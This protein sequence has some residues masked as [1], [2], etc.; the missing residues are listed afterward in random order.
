VSLTSSTEAAHQPV[1]A[2]GQSHG[3]ARQ[4]INVAM[5]PPPV[6]SLNEFGNGYALGCPW[7]GASSGPVISTPAFHFGAPPMPDFLVST[8]SQSFG[9]Q[10]AHRRFDVMRT[11]W[12]QRAYASGDMQQVVVRSTM[13]RQEPGKRKEIMVSVG[14]KVTLTFSSMLNQNECRTSVKQLVKFQL[15]LVHATSN[16]PSSLPCYLV[17]ANGLETL[18]ST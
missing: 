2:I 14:L 16:R 12:Q 10:E 9:Y 17:G 5:P 1:N 18:R 15:V 11:Y 3:G 6:P 7:P 8:Q 13:V 4:L